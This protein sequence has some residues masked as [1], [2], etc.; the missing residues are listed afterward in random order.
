M[1]RLIIHLLEKKLSTFTSIRGKDKL[2][3]EG[4]SFDLERRTSIAHIWACAK[5]KNLNIKCKGRAHTKL[6][7]GEHILLRVI[8]NHTCAPEAAKAVIMNKRAELKRKAA[9]SIG[10][11]VS[12]LINDVRASTSTEYVAHLPKKEALRSLIKRTKK[13]SQQISLTEPSNIDFIIPEELSSIN[14][15]LFVLGDVQIDKNR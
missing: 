12:Q 13:T 7:Q 10:A 1:S 2:N 6:T 5:K 11:K 3:M 4:F 15:D 9:D 14:G 8:G